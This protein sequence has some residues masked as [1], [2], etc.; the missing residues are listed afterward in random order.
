MLRSLY[1]TVAILLL[2]FTA[3][4]GVVVD[5]PDQT[6]RAD[7]SVTVVR[8]FDKAALKNYSTDKAFQYKQGYEG[9][10]LWDRFWHWL[11]GLF[12]GFNT[13]KDSLTTVLEYLLI[14]IAVAGILFLIFKVAGIDVFNLI[15]GTSKSIVAYDESIEDIHAIDLDI[16]IEKA[17]N[18]QNYRFAVRLLYLRLLKQ[19]S[20]AGLIHWEINKTNSVYITELTNIEQRDS[21]TQITRQFEYI[22]YGGLIIDVRV[23]E[24]IKALFT[25]FKIKAS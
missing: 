15:K 11:W 17:T 12:D 24:R 21:F 19:L 3:R 8:H 9:E 7:T 23:F 6:Y 2:G 25:N 14:S 5:K 20:D 1:L 22:W 13:T 10:S 4:A 18:Q 16:E